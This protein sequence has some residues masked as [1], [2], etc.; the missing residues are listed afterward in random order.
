LQT[1]HFIEAKNLD[2]NSITQ[3]QSKPSKKSKTKNPVFLITQAELKYTDD[4]LVPILI[5]NIAK[6]SKLCYKN[7]NLNICFEFISFVFSLAIINILKRLNT[8]K[9]YSKIFFESY[10]IFSKA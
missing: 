3:N 6:E 4:S 9:N 8:K 2:L 1:G 10:Q 5:K 7:T